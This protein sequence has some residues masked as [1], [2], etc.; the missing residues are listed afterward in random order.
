MTVPAPT[1]SQAAAPT[2]DR[3]SEQR[4]VGVDIAR[5]LAIFGMFAAHVLVNV[6]ELGWEPRYPSWRQGFQQELA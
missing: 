4:L 2:G 3:A 6:G 5:A 1:P